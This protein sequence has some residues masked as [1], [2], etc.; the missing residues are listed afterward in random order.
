MFIPRL[1]NSHC[2]MNITLTNLRIFLGGSWQ[3]RKLSIREVAGGELV[4][5][6]VTVGEVVLGKKPNT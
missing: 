6:E 4:I 1:T 5:G 2:I 3:L